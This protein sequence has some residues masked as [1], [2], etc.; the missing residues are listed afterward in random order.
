NTETVFELPLAV[1]TNCPLGSRTIATDWALVR[2]GLPLIMIS[3][4]VD[5]SS[6]YPLTSPEGL[7]TYRNR[8]W[9]STAMPRGIG[10]PGRGLPEVGVGMPVCVSLVKAS[11]LPAASFVT[12]RSGALVGGG[13]G[14]VLPPVLPA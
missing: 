4:P 13:G 12:E 10:P 1:S 7:V 5:E 11:R 8:F 6:R 14:V 3:L 9:G 2:N